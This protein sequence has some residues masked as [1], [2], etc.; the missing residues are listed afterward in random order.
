MAGRPSAGNAVDV[1]RGVR[2]VPTRGRSASIQIDDAIVVTI[3]YCRNDT[4]EVRCT[5]AY[6]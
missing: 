3:Q 1:L 5:G 4:T 6:F 2:V